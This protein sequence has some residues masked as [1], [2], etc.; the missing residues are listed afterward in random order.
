MSAETTQT[1][2]AV[3]H[4]G[5]LVLPVSGPHLAIENAGKRTLLKNWKREVLRV[6]ERMIR[7][8]ATLEQVMPNTGIYC[9]TVCAIDIDFDEPLLAEELARIVKRTLGGEP[10]VRIGQSPRILLL[11]RCNT[12]I[13]TELFYFTGPG[14]DDFHVDILGAGTQ[15]VAFGRH[16]NGNEYRWIGASPLSVPMRDLPLITQQDIKSLESAMN[17][18]LGLHGYALREVRYHPILIH[19]IAAG[20]YQAL[21]RF[22]WLRS[23]VEWVRP[24]FKKIMRKFEIRRD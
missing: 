3:W 11:Y 15:F 19:R 7:S 13:R 6:N 2:I 1:R 24:W 4:N 10:L 18:A 14:G 5:Y 12:P 22:P 21:D 16:P 17:T 23:H 20:A 9:Q 8:W